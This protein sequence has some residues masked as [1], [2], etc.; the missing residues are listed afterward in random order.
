MFDP[1]DRPFYAALAPNDAQVMMLGFLSVA[2][3][4][5]GYLDQSRAQGDEAL[6][7]ARRLAQPFT[8]A[9]ALDS[10]VHA[11]V[12]VGRSDIASVSAAVTR[13][14]EFEALVVEQNFQGLLGAGLMHRGWCRAAMGQTQEGIAVLDEGFAAYRRSGFRFFMPS[15]L[16][17]QADAYRRAGRTAAALARLAEAVEAANAQG[18]RYFEA[19]IHRLRGEV[20]RDAGDHA[21]AEECFRIAI[22]IARGQGAKLW[23][24]RSSVSLA[25]MLRDQGK[26]SAARDRLAPIYGWFTEGFDTPDLKEAKALLDELA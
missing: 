5:L 2:L 12:R 20:L 7:V 24:L 1:A 19:E 15:A 8:L 23:E 9:M 14:Q 16:S 21:A 25:Q 3:G 18:E 13:N 22:D 6:A 11:V 17:L 26:R 10:S 4:A